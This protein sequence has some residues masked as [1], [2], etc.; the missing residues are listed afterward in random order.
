[1]GAGLIHSSLSALQNGILL[2]SLNIVRRREISLVLRINTSTAYSNPAGNAVS[3]VP[4]AAASAS[5]SSVIFTLANTSPFFI[6]GPLNYD[7][8]VFQVTMIPDGDTNNQVIQSA[9]GS[10]FLSDP[11][12]ILFWDSGLDETITYAIEVANTA[13]GP[14]QNQGFPQF[15]I[16]T[17]VTVSR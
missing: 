15:G 14:L 9:N 1:M 3:I 7:H 5:G 4:Q 16:R 10:S 2:L 17:L 8:G 12:Q 13:D 6:L 11:Q